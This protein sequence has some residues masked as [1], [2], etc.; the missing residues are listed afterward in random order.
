MTALWENLQ[1]L[2]ARLRP[3]TRFMGVV[4]AD[5]YGH[6]L[7]PVARALE[8]Y[9]A[10]GLAVAFGAEAAELRDQHIRLPILVMGG[11]YREWAS[12]YQHYEVTATVFDAEAARRMNAEAMAPLRVH[13]KVDTGMGRLGVPLADLPAFLEQWRAWPKLIL[14]GVFSHFACADEAD[15]SLTETQ[16]KRFE[17][18]VEAVRAHGHRPTILHMANSAATLRYPASHFDMVRVGLALYGVQPGG[19][20]TGERP[21]LRPVMRVWSEVALVKDLPEGAT[22]GYGA[23]FVARRPTRLI[24]IPL[25]Y[26]D[27]FRRS[28]TGAAV[29]LR[30]RRIPVVGRVSMDMIVAD[31]SDHPE[32][33]SIRRSEPVEIFGQPGADGIRA[34]DHAVWAGTVPYEILTGIG[35]RVNR[36]IV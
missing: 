25:G 19:D 8:T 27:G 12:F 17:Q 23:E 10:D 35:G 15:D 21:V 26:A 6:G 5:A 34:E 7:L 14:D 36:R 24:V 28:A 16:I 1:S 30:G 32:A 9:G 18:A 22:S 20:P 2:R 4:K 31:A 29:V 33:A 13:L 3:G 11:P